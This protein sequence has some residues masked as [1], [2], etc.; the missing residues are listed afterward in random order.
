MRPVGQLPRDDILIELL[1]RTTE[2]RDI[3]EMGWYVM[4]TEESGD[5]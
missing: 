1:P 3:K 2:V 5:W 4:M